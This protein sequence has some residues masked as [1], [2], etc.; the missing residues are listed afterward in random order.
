MERKT[1]RATALSRDEIEDLARAV[2]ANA[3]ALAEEA[4]ILLEAGRRARAYALAETAAE[5]LGKVV[6]VARVGAELAMGG[7]KVDWQTFW[8]KFADHGSKAWSVAFLDYLV[9]EQPGAWAGGEIETIRA[10]EEGMATAQRQAAAMVA[11]HERSLYVDFGAG[12]ILTPDDPVVQENAEMIVSA[13]RELATTMA[14]L[15]L[16]ADADALKRIASDPDL[17]RHAYELRK[18][19][20]RL[21]Y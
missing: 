4:T 18:R 12:K 17:R 11:L 13:V 21:R 20:N 16:V 9:S 19:L 7:G 5:E 1:G 14:N 2:H 10:D 3:V 8:G 15:G 6:L